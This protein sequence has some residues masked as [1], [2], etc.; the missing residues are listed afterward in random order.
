MNVAIDNVTE[1]EEESS[2]S[3]KGYKFIYLFAG[4]GENN[5]WNNLK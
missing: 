5:N 1:V 2:A 4:I 3:L